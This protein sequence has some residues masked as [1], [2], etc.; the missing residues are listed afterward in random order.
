MSHG[1]LLEQLDDNDV[2]WAEAHEVMKMKILAAPDREDVNKGMRD[3]DN[4]KALL[5]KG[6]ASMTYEDDTEKA[7]IKATFE[8]F[9][10]TYLEREIEWSEEV[11]KTKLDLA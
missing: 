8:K 2:P 1:V 7:T 4:V 3:L 9:L 10:P 6:G 5:S 11:W